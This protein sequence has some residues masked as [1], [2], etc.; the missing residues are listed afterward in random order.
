MKKLLS[1]V[2]MLVSCHI[3]GQETT[4]ESYSLKGIADYLSSKTDIELNDFYGSIVTFDY[5]IDG[6]KKQDII[7]TM[8]DVLSSNGGY[9][10]SESLVMVPADN[11]NGLVLKNDKGS[12]LTKT[13]YDNIF[14][15]NNYRDD[16]FENGFLRVRRNGKFGFIDILGNEI[17]PCKYTKIDPFKNDV[18]RVWGEVNETYG[19]TMSGYVNKEGKEIVPCLFMD[20]GELISWFKNG[21]AN[22]KSNNKYGIIDK[23]GNTVVSFDY[24]YAFNFNEGLAAVVKDGKM[25]FVDNKGNIVIPFIYD[26]EAYDFEYNYKFS[27]GLAAVKKEGQWGYIDKSNSVVI[28]FVYSNVEDFHD[29]IAL[30]TNDDGNKGCIDKKGKVVI[31][32]S[33]SEEIEYLGEGFYKCTNNS[34]VNLIN[35]SGIIGVYDTSWDYSGIVYN[36]G[37]IFVGKNKKCGVVD[38]SGKE[39]IACLYKELNYCE[40]SHNIIKAKDENGKIMYFNRAGLSIIPTNGK[41]ESVKEGIVKY[42]KDNKYGFV[43]VLGDEI[44]PC[45]YDEAEDY[46]GG[47]VIVCKGEKWGIIDKNGK[48]TIPCMYDGISCLNNGLAAVD[49]EGKIGFVDT[50]G[51][52]TF[53]YQK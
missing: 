24:D 28:P 40:D 36:D 42:S 12:I 27:D 21:Y 46:H 17:I 49:K 31:P 16:K 32:F 6:V 2:L 37:L 11:G 13:S 25:G 51:N 3:Y 18:A 22:F 10:V 19:A 35:R 48:E 53:D 44:V 26:N 39:V 50:K 52:S 34:K 47:Y 29:G 30:V 15:E 20:E 45:I 38:A 14:K 43:S 23:T 9:I 5:E 7:T 4:T 41:F 8:G 1:I 33:D